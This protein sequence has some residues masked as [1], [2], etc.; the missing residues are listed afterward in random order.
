MRV[1]GATFTALI[2]AAGLLAGCAT[3]YTNG[4]TAADHARDDRACAEQVRSR[5]QTGSV[6]TRAGVLPAYRQCMV[7]AGWE[8]REDGSAI[9]Y[10][11][12]NWGSA[13]GGAISNTGGYVTQDPARGYG[14]TMP[15]PATCQTLPINPGNPRLG[16]ITS[17]P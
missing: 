8:T 14:P 15:F 11:A 17:C 4:K 12:P 2:A 7:G 1:A 16:T 10:P 5:I 3:V 6:A 9:V 13:I